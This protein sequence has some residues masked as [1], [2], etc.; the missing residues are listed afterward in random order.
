[1]EPT[2][3]ERLWRMAQKRASFKKSLF[4]YMIIIAFLWATWWLTSGRHKG[5]VG[6]PWP[7]WVM[8]GWGIMLGFQYF[9][10]YNGNG[11]DLVEDEYEKL[12]RQ[13]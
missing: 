9:K 8:L 12:R 5:F 3:D 6:T 13:Q 7:V 1:M 10:A 2:K 4:G 11:R